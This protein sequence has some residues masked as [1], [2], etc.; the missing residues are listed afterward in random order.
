M[1]G[2]HNRAP[3]LPTLEVPDGWNDDGTRRVKVIQ[4]VM[5]ED[6]RHDSRDDERCDGC[7]WQLTQEKE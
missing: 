6:C 5:S 2:C 4:F 7:R 1:N 3:F